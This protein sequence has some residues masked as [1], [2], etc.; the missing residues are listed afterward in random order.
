MRWKSLSLL[1]G[2]IPFAVILLLWQLAAGAIISAVYLPPVSAIFEAFATAFQG[3]FKLYGIPANTIITLE[4]MA[5]GYGLA[6]AIGAP[7]GI[8]VGLSKRLSKLL[9][10]TIEVFRVVPGV[11]LIPFFILL[12]GINNAMYVAFV[13]FGSVWPILINAIDGVRGVEPLYFE[14]ARSY[15]IR[16]F[17]NFRKIIIPGASPYIF[18]GMRVSL[19]L[20]LL[21]TVAAEIVT[22][23]N[24]LGF[25]VFEAMS[26]SNIR[27]LYALIFL[28]GII[29]F[30][31]NIGFILLENRLMG[32]HKK[33][34]KG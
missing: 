24:G 8:G 12:I 5:L 11:A 31:L 20:A 16:G 28:L 7:V 4:R 1:Y 23:Y 26:F 13:A 30:L 25:S 2:I 17:K 19:L 33:M 34:G 14:V 22:G 6:V 21:I 18:S 29:G 27:I 32:W 15:K 9:E 10:P 3:G